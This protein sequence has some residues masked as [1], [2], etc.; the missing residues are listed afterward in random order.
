MIN[1]LN[2]IETGLL[3]GVVTI[4]LVMLIAEVTE[5][6]RRQDLQDKVLISTINDL[7]IVKGWHKRWNTKEE[8]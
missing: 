2:L 6:R 7:T 1:K 5:M 3:W 8:Q 4:L